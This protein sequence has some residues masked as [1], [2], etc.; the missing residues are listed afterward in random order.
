MICLTLPAVCSRTSTRLSKLKAKE[1]SPMLLK[2]QAR[3]VTVLCLSSIVNSVVQSLQKGRQSHQ[4]AVILS[5]SGGHIYSWYIWCL[6]RPL[7][8]FA[9]QSLFPC[10]TPIAPT[11]SHT[12]N[13]VQCFDST[14]ALQAHHHPHAAAG[15][16]QEE[17]FWSK[18]TCSYT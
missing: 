5:F 14:E 11:L 3:C 9:Q 13:L 4:P 6:P 18:A 7:A 16:H 15:L 10:C 8:T 12:S 17:P 2:A 1:S